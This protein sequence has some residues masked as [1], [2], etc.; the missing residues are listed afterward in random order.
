M[1]ALARACHQP[2]RRKDMM[3]TP[4]HPTNSCSMLLAVVRMVIAIRN[5]SR[6]F[7]NRG[8]SGSEAIYQLVNSRIDQVISRATGM[9]S[10]VNRSNVRLICRLKLI[11]TQHRWVVM[12]SI[13]MDTN[14]KR[15]MRLMMVASFVL[16]VIWAGVE[17]GMSEG[18]TR[19][20]S[21]AV[22]EA[23][24]IRLAMCFHLELHQVWPTPKAG[25]L[26]MSFESG[27]G[28]RGLILGR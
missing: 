15:G 6:Y 11:L 26:L 17:W 28:A 5:M 22:M 16:F 4:S 10:S 7:E 24:N 18:S 3:P 1:L 14:V 12:V 25:G 13:P 21:I 19:V 20:A 27:K 9:N 8:R 2:I 23:W